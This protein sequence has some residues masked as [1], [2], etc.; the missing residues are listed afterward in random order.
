MT[1]IQPLHRVA[2]HD[3]ALLVQQSPTPA[4]PSEKSLQ[5]KPEKQ[6]HLPPPQTPSRTEGSD[7]TSLGH[8]P[9][10]AGSMVEST[11]HKDTALPHA[12][13]QNDLDKAIKQA[14]ATKDLASVDDYPCKYLHTDRLVA[15]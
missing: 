5:L 8:M 13:P 9:D 10:D 3:D 1:E 14:Q 4:S 7:Q 15:A 6:G 12:Y 2:G 11:P